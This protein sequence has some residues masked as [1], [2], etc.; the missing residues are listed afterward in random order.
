[1]VVSG[2]PEAAPPVVARV[3][4]NGRRWALGS[5]CRLTFGRAGCDIPF[6]AEPQ[7]L[8]VS[9]R[10]GTLAESE[11]A[12][13]ISNTGRHPLL[14]LTAD[15]DTHRILSPGIAVSAG[16]VQFHIIA[17]GTDGERHQIDVVHH[18][19]L[20]V[21]REQ[22]TMQ[23]TFRLTQTERLLL[24]ALCEP[25]LRTGDTHAPFAT[26]REIARRVN[27]DDNYVRSRLA[28]VRSN[29]A[30]QGIPGLL[31]DEPGPAARRLPDY[32]VR[33]GEWVIAAGLVTADDLALLA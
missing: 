29:L 19:R 18:R 25:R 28:T 17:V 16:L 27:R 13:V 22:D 33:L 9:R 2:V 31:R 15:G 4:A 14:L 32:I 11:G 8:R 3:V 7:D 20:Q 1:M 10:A 6:G 23:L 21:R 30:G 26:Y 5:G 12:I 24:V